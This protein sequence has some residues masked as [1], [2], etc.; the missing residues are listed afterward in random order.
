MK[1]KYVVFS[2]FIILFSSASFA[3]ESPAENP[4]TPHSEDLKKKMGQDGAKLNAN[5]NYFTF[6]FENDLFGSGRD[7]DYTNGTRVSWFRAGKK[8]PGITQSLAKTLPFLN[9]N[10]ATST[11]Y[12]LGQN[13]YTPEAE[14]SKEQD[15]NDR[16]WAAFLY[17]SMTMVTVEKNYVDEYELTLGV[18][19]PLAMGEQVQTTVHKIK[20]V[21][22]PQGWDNQLKNEPGIILAWGRRWAGPLHYILKNGNALSLIPHTGVALGN[23]Y[24]YASLGATLKFSTNETP[25]S[26]KPL[27][28]RPSIPGTGYFSY[29]D[30]V[31]WE[32]FTGFEGRAIA[33]NIFLDGNTFANSYSVHKK[34]LVAD[35]SA[36]TSLTINRTKLSYTLVYRTKEYTTQ[37][38]PSVFG[39]ISLGYNF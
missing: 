5:K 15:P 11:A 21:T 31:N 29:H 27:S 34:P 1:L 33:R 37:R 18:V 25:L 17:T 13:L 38:H 20:R 23:I 4:I 35:L 16:P 7:Q 28:V 9:I 39:S 32:I 14:A 26:D 8:P 22:I 6:V 3:A 30:R 12:S 2:A 10:E 19:G 36:G 24:T